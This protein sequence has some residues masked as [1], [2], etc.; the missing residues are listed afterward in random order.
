M[1]IVISELNEGY[2]DLATETSQCLELGE[3]QLTQDG[4]SD[5]Y[6]Q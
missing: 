2:V 3:D 1:L 4:Y 5:F 6:I